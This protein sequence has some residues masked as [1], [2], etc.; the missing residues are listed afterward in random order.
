M[1]YFFPKTV[2]LL[3]YH[4]PELWF[5]SLLSKLFN[6]PSVSCYVLLTS[7]ML[8][9]TLLFGISS[10]FEKKLSNPI[11]LFILSFL[12]LGISGLFFQSYLNYSLISES[13]WHSFVS[14]IGYSG[15]KFCYVYIF[16]LL[17]II[18]FS[19]KHVFLGLLILSLTPFYSVG[20]LPGIWGGI[21]LLIVCNIVYNK[22]FKLNKA[23]KR[24]LLFFLVYEIVGFYFF[25]KL[26]GVSYT[27]NYASK[28]IT[29]VVSLNQ[30]ISF[31]TIKHFWGNI[32]VY[33]TK[34]SI[35]YIPYFILLLLLGSWNRILWFYL[36][37][38]LLCGA[39]TSTITHGLTDSMQ[40][41]SNVGILFIVVIIYDFSHSCNT[42]L[43][44]K[45]IVKGS[46]IA[47]AF[48]L[49][50]YSFF[51]TVTNKLQYSIPQDDKGF[52]LNVAHS[53]DNSNMPIVVFYNHNYY[54]NRISIRDVNSVFDKDLIAIHQ[55]KNIPLVTPV[56][57]SEL[58]S[59]MNY[60]DYADTF[61][62]A[63]F[64]PLNVWRSQNPKHNL[65]NFIS[66]F[67]LKYFYFM[68]GVEIPSFI[69][70]NI[71]EQ[72][73]SPLSKSSFIIIK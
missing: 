73:V 63:Q 15:T 57:N 4:Y 3:P 62:Y 7:T 5:T 18:L 21:G 41:S 28:H 20:L 43:E 38:V 35:F 61:Y 48:C 19:N 71:K 51:N 26:L 55:L 16:A 59:K 67:N 66:R 6:N 42:F 30:R 27:D 54:Q 29:S 40:F 33:F 58:Y 24:I 11:V 9:G 39:V 44:S 37:L 13:W 64:T 32:V 47:L 69:Q 70:N 60:M 49:F 2:G 45:S 22:L 52:V 34:V 10:L 14:V 46:L 17:G 1:N 68:Q 25:Y 56:A 31:Q 50:L 72:F 65:Q 8:Y 36:C 23:E 53:I 12:L